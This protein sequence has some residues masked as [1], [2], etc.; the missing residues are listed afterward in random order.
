[1]VIL[2]VIKIIDLNKFKAIDEMIKKIENDKTCHFEIWK[3]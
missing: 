1:M 2:I 3:K